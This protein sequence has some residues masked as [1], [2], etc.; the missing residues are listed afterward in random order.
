MSV[1]NNK[2][3]KITKAIFEMAGIQIDGN[4]P[5]DIQVRNKRF[6]ERAIT[7][8]ELGF[9]ESYVDGWWDVEKVD[10]LIT[11]ILFAHLNEKIKRN[12]SVLFNLYTIRL[13]N[14]QSKRR[15]FI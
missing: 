11:R 10:E 14:L 4:N 8:G 2:Y 13:F 9:G 15:A 3:E 5:W 1:M 6:Y 7:E 12:F